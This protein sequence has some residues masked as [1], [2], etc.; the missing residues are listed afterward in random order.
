MGLDAQLPLEQLQ[1]SSESD[2][3]NGGIGHAAEVPLQYEVCVQS[4]P[5]KHT[6][7][8]TAAMNWQAL[9]QQGYART[10]YKNNN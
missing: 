4:D 10:F 1:G 6:V 3:F 2:G 7:C 5:D 9:L 8:G